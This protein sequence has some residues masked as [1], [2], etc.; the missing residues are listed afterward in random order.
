MGQKLSGI[1]TMNSI[2]ALTFLT[3]IG[4]CILSV[5]MEGQKDSDIN[6]RGDN[7]WKDIKKD[8]HNKDHWWKDIKN[9]WKDIKK[10]WPRKESDDCK[11][12]DSMCPL[13]FPLDP[14]ACMRVRHVCRK[15]CGYC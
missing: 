7:W 10:D 13:I 6:L 12:T 4:M 3:I 11:D 8:W 9:D 2:S 15:S 5:R 1:P 14:F